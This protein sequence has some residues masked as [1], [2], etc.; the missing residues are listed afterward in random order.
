MLQN[1]FYFAWNNLIHRRL[2]SW[3]TLLGIFIGVTAVV[4]LVGLGQ[5]LKLAVNAQ[6]SISNSEIITIQAGGLST[7]GPPGSGVVNPLTRDDAK[8]INKISSVDNSVV[9]IIKSEKVEFNDVLEVGLITNVVDDSR[10]LFNEVFEMV[11]ESGRLLKSGDRKKV[12]LGYN[13]G[14]EDNG[15]NKKIICGNKIFLNGIEF[16]VI[17]ISKKKGS[18]LLDNLI[19]IND[20]DILD[21]FLNKDEKDRADIIAVHVKDKALMDETKEKIEKLLRKRRNVKKGEE[22]FEVSTPESTLSIINSIITGIQIFIGLIASIS[23]LVGIVGIVNTM[24]TS[25]LERKQQIGIMKA[26]GAKNS[27]IFLQFL[28]ESGMLGFIG[29]LVG[30]VVGSVISF[31]GT[32]GIAR[33]LGS[34]INPE[35]NLIFIIIILIGAFII[36]AI[37]GIIPA[38]QAAKQ[39]PV[40]SLRGN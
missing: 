29:G 28:V 8:E 14:Q 20:Q 26:I 21:Y 32:K 40:D 31:F 17:G 35:I 2:R 1:Y 22:N 10:N 6:F 38:M 24:T 33:F 11:A 7:T 36:G 4:S 12:Y 39:N 15:F 18:F 25:V 5:G 23:I 27:D 30:V 3:L 13:F 37:A 16:E 34:E 9:R 19:V